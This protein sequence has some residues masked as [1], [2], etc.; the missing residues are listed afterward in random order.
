MCHARSFAADPG[1]QPIPTLMHSRWTSAA[2][3]TTPSTAARGRAHASLRCGSPR[4]SPMGRR[5]RFEL[6]RRLPG[7]I[8]V[9]DGIRRGVPI[10]LP[11]GAWYDPAEPRGGRSP[12]A[13]TVI[14]NVLRVHRHLVAGAGMHR[15]A[16][17][18]GGRAVQRQSATD[19][20]LRPSSGREHRAGQTRPLNTQLQTFAAR[21]PTA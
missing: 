9:A 15:T 13:S 17:Y 10:Q 6:T 5:P 18:R 14:P 8:G 21:V 19:S 2:M 4:V 1:C 12:C 11:T 16:H 7:R 20:S 3:A